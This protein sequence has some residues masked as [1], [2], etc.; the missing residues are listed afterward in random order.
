MT[1]GG[2]LILLL[3]LSGAWW[4]NSAPTERVV[5]SAQGTSVLAFPAM[6][7]GEPI[8]SHPVRAVSGPT[9]KAKAL[10][11]LDS[12]SPIN[13]TAES[14]AANKAYDDAIRSAEQ[15][16][17][18]RLTQHPSAQARAVGLYLRAHPLFYRSAELEGA[19]DHE[20]QVCFDSEYRPK[21]TPECKQAQAR[22]VATLDRLAAKSLPD[23]QALVT[24]ATHSDDPTTYAL[25]LHA[26]QW[27][28]DLQVDEGGGCKQLSVA[29]WAQLD[30]A[31][32]TPWLTMAGQATSAEQWVDAIAHA[33]RAA[34]SNNTVGVVAQWLQAAADDSD[35]AMQQ[36]VAGAATGHLMNDL[37]MFANHNL[38]L[39]NCSTQATQDAN[40]R[41]LCD[42]VAS[43]MAAQG[44][45]VLDRVIAAKV[46]ASVGW[47][48]KRTENLRDENQALLW[49]MQRLQGDAIHILVARFP[50]TAAECRAPSALL[51]L[52]SRWGQAGQV[53]ALR[54]QLAASGKT[55]EQA[56]AE[57]RARRAKLRQSAPASA[58]AR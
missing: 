51:N 45:N 52:G 35:A 37:L 38:T 50:R 3:L 4:V 7:E 58:P 36:T 8:S 30:P 15:T 25:A 34:H 9:I 31:N 55:L 47:P 42:S 43:A 27:R 20:R 21:D 18:N 6:P 5:P 23:V 57:H 14:E 40:R 28:R 17:F 33:A 48:A 54:E 29:R 46:G 19:A 11:G 1:I 44:D 16:L 56:V 2:L 39:E 32:M 12:R 41:Q 13:A 26:C 22:R 49:E 53:A 24:L 10:C